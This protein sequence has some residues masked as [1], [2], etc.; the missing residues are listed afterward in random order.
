MSSI[1]S[2]RCGNRSLTIVP[3]LPPGRN[4]HCGLTS[5]FCMFDSPPPAPTVLPSADAISLGLWSNVSMCDTPPELKMKITRFALAGKCGCLG[6]SGSAGS[7]LRTLPASAAASS[8]R[9][10]GNSS[11]PPTS[12]RRQARRLR[13]KCG[14]QSAECEAATIISRGR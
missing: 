5:G 1:F 8:D 9:I 2:R 4:S 6:V 3:H 7:S 13:R 14:L 11:D 12:E 10:A